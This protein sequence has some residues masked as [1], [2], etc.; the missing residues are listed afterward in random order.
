LL[1]AEAA[2]LGAVTATTLKDYKE[3][4][5]A[6]ETKMK[7]RLSPEERRP[8]P[9]QERRTEAKASAG[10]ECHFCRKVGHKKSECEALTKIMEAKRRGMKKEEDDP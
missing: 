10:L 5:P 4:C 6:E 3:F 9:R 8:E 1:S 7:R 2:F